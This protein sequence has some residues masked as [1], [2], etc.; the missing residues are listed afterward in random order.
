[1]HAA[2]TA[3]PAKPAEAL[4]NIVNPF[5]RQTV[6]RLLSTEEVLHVLFLG[7]G[8]GGFDMAPRTR[9]AAYMT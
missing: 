3:R 2:R 9:R 5:G 6:Q 8:S 1:V 4:G 7:A